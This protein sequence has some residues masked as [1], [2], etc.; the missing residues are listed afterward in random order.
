MRP[1]GERNI[2]ACIARA[3]SKVDQPFLAILVEQAMNSARFA[4]G[5]ACKLE[6]MGR[7]PRDLSRKSHKR[8]EMCS[9]TDVVESRIPQCG[10]S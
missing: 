8:R 9:F 10:G 5:T 7:Q 6:A 4:K 3:T 2:P 1:L